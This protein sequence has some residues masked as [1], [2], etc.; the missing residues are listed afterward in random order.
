MQCTR[1]LV[2]DAMQRKAVVC[3]IALVAASACTARDGGAR[4][5]DPAQSANLSSPPS[6]G[7]TFGWDTPCVTTAAQGIWQSDFF[8]EI[9]GPDPQEFGFFAY[10]NG[11]VDAVMGV[12]NGPGSTFTDMGPIVRFNPNGYIDVRDGSTYRADAAV[13]YVG[14]GNTEHLVQM[15]ID[16]TAHTYSVSV[17]IG[18]QP[19]AVV[20]T[21]YAFR[22]EQASLARGDNFVREVDSPTGSVRLCYPGGSTHWLR[23][24]AGTGWLAQPMRDESGNIHV[25]FEAEPN[26]ANIDAVMGLAATTPARFT[27]LATIVRFSPEGVIDVRDGSGYRADATV[28][29]QSYGTYIFSFDVDIAAHTYSVA[30]YN[31]ITGVTTQLATDYAFRTEQSDVTSLASFGQYVDGDSGELIT[32]HLREAY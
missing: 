7:S 1:L 29:Y 30:V 2:E 28:T 23:S 18:N 24:D 31:E 11:I 5:G 21:N 8:D 22:T 20:A 6:A 10:P 19:E 32:D 13:P 3:G 4:G 12:A 9:Y 27:D 16:F 14:D 26:I 25:Q 17:Y 15:F